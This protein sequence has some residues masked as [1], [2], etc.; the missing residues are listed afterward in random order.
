MLGD[1]CFSPFCRR[2]TVR[3]LVKVKLA[4]SPARPLYATACKY[5]IQ[6]LMVSRMG[7]WLPQSIWISSGRC[8][9][10]SQTRETVRS[11]HVQT[12]CMACDCRRA[13]YI[14]ALNSYSFSKIAALCDLR[15]HA[16]S[17]I[18]S[19]IYLTPVCG[20]VA[21]CGAGVAIRMLVEQ[22]FKLFSGHFVS[23]VRK[24]LAAQSTHI[25]KN[26]TNFHCG[27]KQHPPLSAW[28]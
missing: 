19:R 17:R 21:V 8:R 24:I 16:P 6:E 14:W 26:L 28:R 15:D 1:L 13:Q 11:S 2:H 20:T 9:W 3:K 10:W 22:G 4:I 18:W 7:A 23:L 25:W 27:E 12:A 5:A